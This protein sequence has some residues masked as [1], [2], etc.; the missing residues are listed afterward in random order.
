MSIRY[1]FKNNQ[2]TFSFELFPPKTEEGKKTL[3]QNLVHLK[4]LNPSFISVTMGAMGSHPENTFEIVKKIQEDHKI[5][6]VAHLTCVN[7]SRDS[8]LDSLSELKQMKIQNLL[9]LRGDPSVGS[10][11][12]HPPKNGFRYASELVRFIRE[13]TGDTFSIGVAGYPEGHVECLDKEKDLHHLK[14]KVDAGAEYI[15]TQLFFDND[16]YFRFAE[17][18]R[19]IGI[20]IPI[21]PGIMPITN[22]IQLEKFTS[23][24]GAKIPTPLFEKLEKIKNDL[25]AIRNYGVEYAVKQCEELLKNDAPGLHFYILNQIGSIQKIYQGLKLE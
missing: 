1:Y 5:S 21:I 17:R 23:M 24:C 16:D 12:F 19:K 10:T 4:K 25:E 8:I 2:K 15:L 7:V 11:E 22:F 13:K 20:S 14:M 3:Y 18:A 6:G 9:C